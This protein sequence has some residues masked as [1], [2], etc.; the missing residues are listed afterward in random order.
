MRRRSIVQLVV[1]GLLFGAAAGAVAVFIP[2]LPAADAKEADRID[3]VF[4]FTTIDLRRRS[5]RSSPR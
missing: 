2:W 4:W 3:F 1:L 5:S